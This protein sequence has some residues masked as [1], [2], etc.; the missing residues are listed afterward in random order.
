MSF[1]FWE[2]WLNNASLSHNKVKGKLYY[3]SN[4]TSILSFKNNIICLDLKL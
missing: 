1:F 2:R 4:V 3:Y